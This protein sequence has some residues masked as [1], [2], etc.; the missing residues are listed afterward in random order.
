[1]LFVISFS[2]VTALLI[3][4]LCALCETLERRSRFPPGR[5]GDNS[6]SL[7]GMIPPRGSSCLYAYSVSP[8]AVVHMSL[9]AGP[10]YAGTAFLT[11]MFSNWNIHVLNIDPTSQEENSTSDSDNL[12]TSKSQIPQMQ[13]HF[14]CPK[15]QS[16]LCSGWTLTVYTERLVARKPKALQEVTQII[17]ISL[18]CLCPK[19]K[20]WCIKPAIIILLNYSSNY[21]LSN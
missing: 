10:S 20:C 4:I 16:G 18:W 15:W 19:S 9:K 17:S 7:N 12:L 21:I 14:K 2:N 11:Q 3:S 5:V 1:M 13:C 6:K 8:A